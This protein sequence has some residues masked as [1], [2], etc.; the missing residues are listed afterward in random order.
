M[1]PELLVLLSASMVA[2]QIVSLVLRREHVDDA[3]YLGLLI[4]VGATLVFAHVTHR[5][6]SM[7]AFVAEGLAV[8]LTFAPRILDGLERGALMRDAFGRAARVA[9]VR[10]LLTPGRTAARRR[11]QLLDLAE[12][13]AGGGAAVARRLRALLGQID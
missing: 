9:M 10:E 1:T 12:T 13:R 2:L 8:M 11:R 3:P 6:E 4:V 7:L 5:Q